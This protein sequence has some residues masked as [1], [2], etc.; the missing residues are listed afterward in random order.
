MIGIDVESFPTTAW[1][2]LTALGTIMAAVVA[3][4]L[5]LWEGHQARQRQVLELTRLAAERDAAVHADRQRQK[6]VQ[7]RQVAAWY[8][9][10]RVPLGPE[11]AHGNPGDIDGYEVVGANYS[12]LPIFDV[13]LVGEDPAG[14]LTQLSGT[15]L[16]LP[17]EST[18]LFRNQEDTFAR[19]GVRF[20]DTSE[21]GRASCRERVF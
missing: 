18:H 16:L 5:G 11:D 17:N 10:K 14:L 1:D 12:Q 13:E 19:H 20:R 3:L 21:I 8:K 4:F 15:P 6:E 9:K 2:V 7:A